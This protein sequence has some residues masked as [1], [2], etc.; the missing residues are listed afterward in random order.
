VASSKRVA[1]KTIFIFSGLVVLFMTL[2]PQLAIGSFRVA[3]LVLAESLRLPHR[4]HHRHLPGR[5][6]A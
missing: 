5:V 6:P 1:S 4:R 3:L 2:L